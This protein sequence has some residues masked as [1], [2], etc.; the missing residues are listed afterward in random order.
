MIIETS[1]PDSEVVKCLCPLTI[2]NEDLARG[3]DI[4]EESVAVSIAGQ[5]KSL[6]NVAAA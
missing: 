1:G 2:S 5:Q 3:L 4:L 6:S